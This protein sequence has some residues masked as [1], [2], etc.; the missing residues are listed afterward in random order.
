MSLFKQCAVGFSIGF[1]IGVVYY[2]LFKRRR[3]SVQK[4]E[5]KTVQKPELQ[6]MY[7]YQH[8]EAEPGN[9]DRVIVLREMVNGEYSVS[10][11]DEGRDFSPEIVR[12]IGLEDVKEI[13]DE[14]AKNDYYPLD[15]AK[16]WRHY[17]V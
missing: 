10:T 7:I 15:P 6:K 17:E 14:M 16:W 13:I 11:F 9:W 1:T 12:P 2:G 4:P 5:L 8:R 3:A